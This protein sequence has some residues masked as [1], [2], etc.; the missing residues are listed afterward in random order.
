MSG[1]DDATRTELEAAVF[2]RLVEHLRGRTDVQNIDLMNL[3]GFCRNCLSNWYLDAARARDLELTKDES[4][5]IVYGMP[6][7]EW[8]ARHQAEASPAQQ[9]AFATS[10]PDH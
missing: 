5:E 2:R 7:D 8:K 4:R 10:K 6:Y 3:A 1:I 9:A